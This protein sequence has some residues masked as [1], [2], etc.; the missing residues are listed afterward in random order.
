MM[1]ELGLVSRKPE[2]F[3]TQEN[4]VEPSPLTTRSRCLSF[5]KGE[6][7]SVEIGSMKEEPCQYKI[8]CRSAGF[9]CV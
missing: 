7:F 3:A 1:N 4:S 5:E 9:R 8:E 6:C 2:V